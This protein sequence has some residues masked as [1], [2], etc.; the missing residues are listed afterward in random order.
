MKKSMIVAFL[1]LA[2]LLV[3]LAVTDGTLAGSLKWIKVGNIWDKIVD[4]TDEGYGAG[5]YSFGHYYYDG[6]GPEWMVWDYRRLAIA[7][8]DWTDAEGQVHDYKMTGYAAWSDEQTEMIPVPDENGVTIKAYYRNAP[9]TIVV[10]GKNIE[11]PFPRRGDEVAPEKI[12][13]TA[14]VMVESHVRTSMGVDIYQKVLAW[15][16]VNHDDYLIYDF[17]FT[18]TG[19][20]DLDDE[21]ELPSQTLNGFYFNR[22]AAWGWH[23]HMNSYYGGK[24]GDSLR[25]L[26]A[27]PDWG[28]GDIDSH[29]DADKAE[30]FLNSPWYQGWAIL[31]ADKSAADDSDDPEQPR[32]TGYYD[33]EAQFMRRPAYELTPEQQNQFYTMMEQGVG[34]VPGIVGEHPLMTGPDIIPNTIHE[35]PMDDQAVLYGNP[36]VYSWTG[37]PAWSTYIPIG[38]FTVGPYTLAPGESIRVV[39]AHVRGS[40]SPQKA[41]EIGKK[42]KNNELTLADAPDTQLPPHA[43]LIYDE[44]GYDENDQVKDMW[45]ST[46]RDSMFATTHAAQWAVEHDY[47]VPV[48]PPAPSIQVS[49]EADAILVEW[50]S[51]AESTADLVG[52]RVY[53]TVGSP[54]YSER[55]NRVVGDYELIYEAPKGTFSY[56]DRTPQRGFNYYY[57]VTAYDDGSHPETGYPGGVSGVAKSLESGKWLNY[58][59]TDMGAARLKR[60]YGDKLSEIRIVPNPYNAKSW[61]EGLLFA[62][63]RKI[64]FY[65]LPPLCTIKI[66]TETGDLVKTLE[67]TDRSGD[68]PWMDPTGENYMGTKSDQVPASGVY[69]AYIEVTE[70]FVDNDTGEI[71]FK[72]G[73][74]IFK[75]FVIIH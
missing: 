28:G 54:Y 64:M 20:I 71:L 21:V 23:G 4:S 63:E 17:T 45:V 3:F 62:E 42:W 1:S 72:K 56:R 65:N 59:R 53:R 73:E 57:F 48:P 67:H 32:M 13:G 41:W 8:K 49:S 51:E 25:V 55:N 70:D 14:D 19:N 7:C 9:P 37:G 35:L 69:I 47:Q 16:Q 34:A 60:V 2:C 15:S 38:I 12:P 46:G 5:A 40:M 61:K 26:Y 29:G 52:Y 30:G 39:W 10:D 33:S 58:T 22:S 74:S 36:Y 31:H 75:H 24:T 50:G 27:Y 18:N 68:E 44:W 43:Q 66:Y 11:D 6:F